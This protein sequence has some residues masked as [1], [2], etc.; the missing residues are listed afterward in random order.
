MGLIDLPAAQPVKKRA[1]VSAGMAPEWAA[2]CQ[3]WYQRDTH[4]TPE[5]AAGFTLVS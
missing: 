5:A 1:P 2:W 4:L 3:S